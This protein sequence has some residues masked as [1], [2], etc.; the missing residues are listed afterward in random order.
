MNPEEFCGNKVLC[1]EVVEAFVRSAA[2]KDI[3]LFSR[4]YHFNVKTCNYNNSAHS[5]APVSANCG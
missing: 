5:W 4:E 1:W 3:Q 2:A